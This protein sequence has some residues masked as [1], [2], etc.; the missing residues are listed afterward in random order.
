[1]NVYSILKPNIRMRRTMNHINQLELGPENSRT[2]TP[3]SVSPSLCS[4]RPYAPR[5]LSALEALLLRR[6][7][8]PHQDG[9]PLS[10]TANQYMVSEKTLAV[11]SLR[12]DQ[13]ALLSSASRY[14]LWNVPVLTFWWKNMARFLN[15]SFGGQA[16]GLGM[17]PSDAD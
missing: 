10:V 1:M 5:S 8:L 14:Q 12:M 9:L 13:L 2:N 4:S 3:H 16:G 7:D 6:V 17:F 15:R 11:P